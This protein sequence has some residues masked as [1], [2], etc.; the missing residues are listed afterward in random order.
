M[1]YKKQAI[2]QF[3]RIRHVKKNT[4]IYDRCRMEKVQFSH[5]LKFRILGNRPS[6]TALRYAIYV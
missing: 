4:Y 3:C 1:P 2:V 6:L 5:F